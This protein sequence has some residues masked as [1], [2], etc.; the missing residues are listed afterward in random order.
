MSLLHPPYTLW[1]LSY[2][3][4]GIALS[5]ALFVDRSISVLVAFFL[6]L[7]IGA[8]SLDETMGNPLKTR[9][10]KKTLYLIGFGALAMSIVIGIYYVLFLSLALLPFILIESF[11][12]VAYNLEIFHG[13]FHSTFF[14][15]LSWGSI[16]FLTGYFVNSLSLTPSALIMAFGVAMLTV[17]Q[18]SLSEYARFFR[19][20]VPEVNALRLTSGGHLPTSSLELIHPAERALKALTI[21]IFLFSIALLIALH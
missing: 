13:A 1:H 15:A 11:F 17:A 14:F 12:A 6:G 18:K 10:S 4:L 9:L 21:T 3:L 2:V 5:P 8:H 19:R 16:P 20:K 7:G